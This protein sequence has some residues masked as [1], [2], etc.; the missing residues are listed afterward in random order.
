MVSDDLTAFATISMGAL[1]SAAVT[2][3]LVAADPEPNEVDGCVSLEVSAPLERSLT[4]STT[5]PNVDFAIIRSADDRREIHLMVGPE[6]RH[7]GWE[8]DA[9]LQLRLLRER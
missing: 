3:A 4:H 9:S 6:G 8:P 1:A 5:D 2:L 7:S